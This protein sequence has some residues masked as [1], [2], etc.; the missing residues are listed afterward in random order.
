M[1]VIENT[2]AC[3]ECVRA[4]IRVGKSAASHRSYRSASQLP[5]HWVSPDN[6]MPS[7]VG[8]EED[9]P[10][11]PGNP[12]QRRAQ[13]QPA[14]SG[15]PVPVC[16]HRADP[17]AHVANPTGMASQHR[18]R[19]MTTVLRVKVSY[20]ARTRHQMR[21][22]DPRDARRPRNSAGGYI[23]NSRVDRGNMGL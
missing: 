5:V 2:S 3:H 9:S 7:S 23:D 16:E 17:A 11:H 13:G 20:G 18:V 6:H 1:S 14:E 19:E 21:R 15:Q 10:A 22:L 12:I 8:A 4:P